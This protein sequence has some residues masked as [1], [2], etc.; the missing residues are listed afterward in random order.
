MV[1]NIWIMGVQD[2]I[3]EVETDCNY[4]KFKQHSYL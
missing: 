1:I 3:Q 2:K 4:S